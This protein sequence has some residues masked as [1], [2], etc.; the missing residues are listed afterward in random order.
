MT[1]LLA[2]GCDLLQILFTYVF[3]CT[4]GNLLNRSER[5]RDIWQPAN[6]KFCFLSI[7]QLYGNLWKRQIRFIV[8]TFLSL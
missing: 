3:S 6:A 5:Q 2:L 7:Y 4:G 1:Y 8:K